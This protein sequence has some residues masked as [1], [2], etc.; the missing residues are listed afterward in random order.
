MQV[1]QLQMLTGPPNSQSGPY[2]SSK[3]AIFKNMICGFGT[4]DRS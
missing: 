4:V 2:F 1:P 3:R